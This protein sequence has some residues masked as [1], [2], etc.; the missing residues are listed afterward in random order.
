MAVSV[1]I[2][3]VNYHPNGHVYVTYDDGASNEYNDLE[4]LQTQSATVDAPT[5]LDLARALA[6]GYWQAINPTMDNSGMILGKTVTLD[7][8][9]AQAL[10]VE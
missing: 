5:N 7:L 3:G 6:L 2:T 1:R 8:T 10:V 4:D 9:M